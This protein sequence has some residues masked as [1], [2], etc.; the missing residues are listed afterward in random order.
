MTVLLPSNSLR[1][2]LIDED[3]L[4]RLGMGIWLNQLPDMALVAEAESGEMAL[5]ILDRQFESDLESGDR[6]LEP[7]HQPINLVLLNVGL[8]RQNPNQIQGLNLCRL[9]KSRYP[10]LPVLCLSDVSEPVVM[11][12]ARQSGANGYCA[13]NLESSAM[14]A[15]MRLV[16]AGQPYWPASVAEPPAAEPILTRPV[17]RRPAF[18][19]D[20]LRLVAFRRSLRLS[21][22]EQIEVALDDVMAELQ[23]LDLSLLDRAILAGKSREL[24]AA[25]WIVS[26]L[27][28]TPSLESGLEPGRPP[29]RP[30]PRQRRSSQPGFSDVSP[31]ICRTSRSGWAACAY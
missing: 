8:G 10:A 28:A 26:G 15:V 23:N 20:S 22:I 2:L 30:A 29:A 14:A 19:L 3:P 4:F 17:A 1:L 27:L 6:A 5:Q 12:A 25:R 31:A 24:R 13:K 16:A 11:A 18:R 21:G 9:L 7:V